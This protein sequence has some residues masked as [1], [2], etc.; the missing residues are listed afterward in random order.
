MPGGMRLG[1][2]REL[3]NAVNDWPEDESGDAGTPRCAGHQ[4][5]VNERGAASPMNCYLPKIVEFLGY[6]SKA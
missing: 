2:R 5:R 3:E 6:D 4:E 1:F